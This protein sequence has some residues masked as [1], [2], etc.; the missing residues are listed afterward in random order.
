MNE[1]F[2]FYDF[3][4]LR[5]FYSADRIIIVYPDSL[6]SC[7]DLLRTLAKIKPQETFLVR[8]QCDKCTADMEKT[9]EQELQTD[10]AYLDSI[11]LKLPIL[12]SSATQDENYL[13]NNQVFKLIK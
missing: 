6:K 10:R 1:D 5:F 8:T 11:N 12:G 4:T 2:V 9:I 13:Q 7:K 3:K